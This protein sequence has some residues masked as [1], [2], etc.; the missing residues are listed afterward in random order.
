MKLDDLDGQ[1]DGAAA[2][3][4]PVPLGAQSALPCFPVDAFPGWLAA[5]VRETARFTQTPCDLGASVGL[6]VLG[7]A[8]GGRAVVEVRGS[9]REPVN[10]FTVVAMPSGTRKS[11][12]FAELTGPLLVTEAGLVAAAGPQI[13]EAET[14][15]KIA[16][17]D[18]EKAAI[19]AAGLDEAGAAEKATADAIAK[20]QLAES[21][22][23]PVMPRLVADDITPEAASSLLAE[24]AGRLAV[25]SAEGGIFATLAGR[26]SAGQPNFEVFLKG[27]SGDMLRGRPQRPRA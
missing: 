8:A 5:Q 16:L 6:A 7:T 10:L 3:E 1:A 4:T 12:V 13:L 20:A 17:R 2:W 24:Q 9:W 14:Q 15:R 23:V 11:A 27:H 19:Q 21:I 18:A 25:L 22:T 26:Y